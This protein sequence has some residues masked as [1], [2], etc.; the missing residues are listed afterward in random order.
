ME[1]Q[2]AGV[3]PETVEKQHREA[4]LLRVVPSRRPVGGGRRARSRE[5]STVRARAPGGQPCD[6][7]ANPTSRR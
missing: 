3:G 2:R 6:H 1:E 5:G 4:A 7:D